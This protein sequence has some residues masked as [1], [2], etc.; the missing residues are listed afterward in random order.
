M[1]D[2]KFMWVDEVKKATKI[3]YWCRIDQLR[4]YIHKLY[5][6]YEDRIPKFYLQICDMEFVD[7]IDQFFAKEEHVD[8][9]SFTELHM[10]SVPNN[11]DKVPFLNE[12]LDRYSDNLHEYKEQDGHE[13]YR[14]YDVND[15]NGRTF[16]YLLVNDKPIIS[17]E[18]IN[19]IEVAPDNLWVIK[20]NGTILDDTIFYECK[21]ISRY[22][23]IYLKRVTEDMIA[24]FKKDGMTD[25]LICN[26]SF[27]APYT[28]YREAMEENTQS[29][30][31]P[32]ETDEPVK[33]EKSIDLLK[34]KMDTE[35]TMN[36]EDYLAGKSKS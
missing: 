28:T 31:A 23:E 15:S 6:K 4:E 10:H 12:R 14:L 33:S 5:I 20:P 19:Y 11:P 16:D 27:K 29:E 8:V 34:E 26:P 36:V 25:Q 17:P 24:L 32:V 9:L 30:E 18:R 22:R 1:R 7:G 35:G 13:I 21:G 3:H 2:K